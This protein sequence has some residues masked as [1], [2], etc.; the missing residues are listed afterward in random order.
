MTICIHDATVA[1]TA[2]ATE[3]SAAERILW[4]IMAQYGASSDIVHGTASGHESFEAN[5]RL[6]RAVVEECLRVGEE[7]LT[8]LLKQGVKNGEFD[9]H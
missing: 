4:T 5:P 9:L 1:E 2:A 3:G 8:A 7:T 6:G